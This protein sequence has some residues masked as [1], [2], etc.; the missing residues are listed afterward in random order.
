MKKTA[1]YADYIYYNEEIH[2]D[3]YL[4]VKDDII[5]GITNNL[6]NFNDYHVKSFEN[7]AIFPGL[8]NTH[9]HLGMGIMR[10]YADDLPLM[11]WLN[12][13]I[14]PA[15]RK[16]LS[17][18][19]VYYST[20]LSLA[21]SIRSGVTCINDMY[22]FAF[23]AKRA[24][25]KAGIRGVVGFGVLENFSKAFKA[26]DDFEET[27]L[28]R[29][30]ICPHALY[31]VPFDV[32]KECSQYAQKRNIL[33]HT[34]LAETIDEEKQILEKY[35]KRPVELMYETGAFDTPSVFAHCVHINESDM[36]IMADKKANVSHCIESNLKLASGF[37]PVKKMMD[38][39]IN[40]SIGTDGVCSNNDLSMIGEMSTVSKFHKAFNMDATAMP[41]E[42][43][44]KM[45]SSNGAKA[46]NLNNIGKLY[47]G[48]K[49][50]FFVLSF[51]AV[52]MTPVYNPISHLVYAAKD[53]DITD[54]YVNGS[55]VMQDR[56][57]LNFNE[58]EIKIYA[59]E[60]AKI[61]LK[62]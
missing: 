1:F 21:E 55:P 35:N 32:M 22:F 43:V 5:E 59:R 47:K 52:H 46:L 54:V 19:F 27:D 41:A 10:G 45:A 62:G 51:D 16:I 12:D 2:T 24:F 50:D 53:N 37:A 30:S 6:D 13:Y 26:A 7:S 44:L 57:L 60:K 4:L 31:T 3:S 14:W 20:L 49:A 39:G 36:K 38:A 58:E 9:N 25:E 56:K 29:L 18:E 11:T 42:T 8:I 48:M 34:H 28:V 17:G 23:D 15:E 40:V 61:L 33:L